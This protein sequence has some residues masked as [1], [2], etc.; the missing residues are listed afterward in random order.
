MENISTDTMLQIVVTVAAALGL[1]LRLDSKVDGL[2]KELKGDIQRLDST[3]DELRKELK[4]DIQRLDSTVDELR[5]ELKDDIQR[6]DD[7]VDALT[8]TVHEFRLETIERL[9]RLEERTERRDEDQPEAL[10]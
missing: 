9:T 5:K 8:N 4:G 2:R 7:K 6:V 1:W 3:V 10:A